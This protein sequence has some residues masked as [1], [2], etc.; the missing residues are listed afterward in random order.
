VIDTG[1]IPGLPALPGSGLL[2]LGGT[3]P[4]LLDGL[5]TLGADLAVAG[6]SSS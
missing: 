3:L 1:W 4:A 5:P 6:G 2:G